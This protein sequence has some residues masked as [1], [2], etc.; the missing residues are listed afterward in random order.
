MKIE[1]EEEEEEGFLNVHVRHIKNLFQ[2]YF[3][4]GGGGAQA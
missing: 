1:E 2:M 3:I 4:T